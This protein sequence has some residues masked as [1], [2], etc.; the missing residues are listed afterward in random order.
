MDITPLIMYVHVSIG[1]TPFYNMQIHIGWERIISQNSKE[2]KRRRQKVKNK[3]KETE[4]RNKLEKQ[5][6][7]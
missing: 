2:R 7:E 5:K 4:K 1:T 3:R 6:E